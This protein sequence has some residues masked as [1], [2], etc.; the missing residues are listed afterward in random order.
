MIDLLMGGSPCQGFSRNGNMFKFD[1]P[2]SK[3]FFDFHRA[4]VTLQPKFFFLE[5]V[6]MDKQS[7][8]LIT[9]MMG[10]QPIKVNSGQFSA[11][12]RLRTY[13]TNIPYDFYQWKTKYNLLDILDKEPDEKLY[14]LSIE[15]QLMLMETNNGWLVK[16]AT[17]HKGY[18]RA[19]IGDGIDFSMP[20]S[21]TRRGRV[22]KKK[23]GTLD[24]SC[25]WGVIDQTGRPRKFSI[26]EIEKL[27]GFYPGYTKGFSD[28]KRKT[29]IGNGWQTDTIDAFFVALPDLDVVVSLFDGISCG[30]FSLNNLAINYNKYYASEIDPSAIQVTQNNFIN[31]HQLGDV[32]KINWKELKEKLQ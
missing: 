17:K 8:A 6:Q 14:K 16:N 25:N 1:D 20:K 29:M 4:Y 28:S 19:Q 21:K 7:E 26:E 13:W 30:Q 22:H 10:V 27:Q 23:I 24:T 15:E 18:L 12:E 32:T 31:T 9:E 2:R 5:N 11:Q 3:L